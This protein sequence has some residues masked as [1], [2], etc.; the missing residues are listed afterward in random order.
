[1]ASVASQED[2]PASLNP[3]RDPLLRLRSHN[4]PSLGSAPPLLSIPFHT[5][6]ETPPKAD[7]RAPVYSSHQVDHPLKSIPSLDPSR[8]NFQ[9]SGTLHP[10]NN[11][12]FPES[13]YPEREDIL[14]GVLKTDWSFGSMEE[15]DSSIIAMDQ[16]VFSVR[17]PPLAVSTPALDPILPLAKAAY[18]AATV[19]TGGLNMA[20]KVYD[21]EEIWGISDGIHTGNIFCNNDTALFKYYDRREGA[22]DDPFKPIAFVAEAP[23]ESQDT[24]MQDVDAPALV[25]VTPT[26]GLRAAVTRSFA[27][28]V[29][30]APRPGD[31][32]VFPRTEPRKPIKGILKTPVAPTPALSLYKAGKDTASAHRSLGWYDSTSFSPFESSGELAEIAEAQKAAKEER[33]GKAVLKETP[34]EE[35]VG[36]FLPSEE[37]GEERPKREGKKYNEDEGD[38][39][40]FEGSEYDDIRTPLKNPKVTEVKSV[41]RKKGKEKQNSL[42]YEEGGIGEGVQDLEQSKPAQKK[43]VQRK[44]KM[45]EDAGAFKPE[46]SSSDLEEEYEISKPKRRVKA[47]EVV[48]AVGNEEERSEEEA[49]SDPGAYQGSED[50]DTGDKEGESED[51]E[52]EPEGEEGRADT[53]AG[54]GS[55]ED[56]E[57]NKKQ[58]GSEEEDDEE[59]EEED[60]DDEEDTGKWKEVRLIKK[61]TAAS[62]RAAK[63]KSRTPPENHTKSKTR[64]LMKR[65]SVES[66]RRR[67]SIGQPGLRQAQADK[68]FEMQERF[69]RNGSLRKVQ[70]SGFIPS[71]TN[72]GGGQR[73]AAPPVPPIFEFPQRPPKTAEQEITKIANAETPESDIESNS[74]TGTS[75]N[76]EEQSTDQGTQAT[77]RKRP[78]HHVE[79]H[80]SGVNRRAET[81]FPITQKELEETILMV[82]E[83]DRELKESREAEKKCQILLSTAKS[84]IDSLC[85]KVNTL[86]NKLAKTRD[87]YTRLEVELAAKDAI[88][89]DRLSYL[90]KD[91]T[92]EDGMVELQGYVGLEG[93][94]HNVDMDYIKKKGAPLDVQPLEHPP[95]SSKLNN[96]PFYHED[97]YQRREIINSLTFPGNVML[98]DYSTNYFFICCLCSN[99]SSVNVLFYQDELIWSLCICL[100]CAEHWCCARCDRWTAPKKPSML[101]ETD[102][103]MELLTGPIAKKSYEASLYLKGVWGDFLVQRFQTEHTKYPIKADLSDSDTP[104]PHKIAEAE[105]ERVGLRLT[106]RVRGEEDEEEFERTRKRIEVRRA[107]ILE[108]RHLECRPPVL[109]E[110]EEGDVFVREPDWDG[111]GD[112]EMSNE[113]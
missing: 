34:Y 9:T 27:S 12:Q 54:S 60:E 61:E 4:L 96:N 41:S 71:E 17:S 30:K 24:E 26:T 44:K 47:I 15:P 66:Q 98:V 46:Q 90:Y 20:G 85:C 92:L 6:D 25:P 81:V 91:T 29:K 99:M 76:I 59:G 5:T 58:S 14:E 36:N 50:R 80:G 55:E 72:W 42:A 32:K 40:D 78:M 86:K 1:M 19:G 38:G 51:D 63:V 33:K 2:I 101:P 103:D 48:Q 73:K 89:H 104:Q 106:G 82:K 45:K 100:V 28:T 68:A 75:D 21:E 84:N 56:D 23:G 35:V 77:I 108:K 57:D 65:M 18:D 31:M 94:D 109:E 64:S 70:L 39:S 16:S 37:S 110:D 97:M 95:F 105:A 102:A 52:E 107:R 22:Q 93:F 74:V 79:K 67:S 111:S 113:G 49:N 7:A 88:G 83:T 8:I 112:M 62:L 69:K 43:K 87:D 13:I 53:N 11:I 10:Q 3:L